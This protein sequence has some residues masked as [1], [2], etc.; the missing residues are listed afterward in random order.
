MVRRKPWA[1]VNF[2]L[3]V[4]VVFAIQPYKW[5]SRFTM[6]LLAAG[7]IGLAYCIDR[8]PARTSTAAKAVVVV[9]A[10]VGLWLCSAKV[11]QTITAARILHLLTL[12]REERTIGKIAYPPF[13][14]VDTIDRHARIA[15][16]T[17]TP[18]V[19][20]APHI[21]FFY[22]L[23]GSHFERRVYPLAGRSEAEFHR[24]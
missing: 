20:S 7:M 11:D 9:L 24:R 12:P 3:P 10:A 17:T 6:V 13:E 4:A 19:G 8:A 1:A 23:F 16:D 15:V 18:A 2:L 5:W 22:P 14:W 21:L